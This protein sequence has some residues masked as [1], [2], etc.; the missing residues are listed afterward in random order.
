[1]LIDVRNNQMNNLKEIYEKGKMENEKGAKILIEELKEKHKEEIEEFTKDFE[2][3]WLQ[4]NPG[5]TSEIL[6]KMHARDTLCKKK[7]YIDAQKLQDEINILAKE[8]YENW[9]TK[10]KQ[11]TYNDELKNLKNKQMKEMNVL[12]KKIK[13]FKDKFET[14]MQA[15]D[16]LLKNKYNGKEKALLNDFKRKKDAYF[17]YNHCK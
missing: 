10:I 12:N 15:E 13:L 1:M 8:H 11:K 2:E 9:N 16:Q 17:K 14:K 5:Y 7:E 6:D 3:K 4:K